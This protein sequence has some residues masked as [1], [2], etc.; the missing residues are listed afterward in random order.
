MA[1]KSDRIDDALRA[2]RSA[3][4]PPLSARVEGMLGSLLP[5]RTASPARGVAVVFAASLA[6]AALHVASNGPRPDAA[7]LPL[8]W[9]V[10]V[11]LAWAGGFLAVLAATMLPRRGS[12]LPDPARVVV[13]SLLGPVAM[14]ALG[15][16]AGGAESPAAATWGGEL[17]QSVICLFTALEI[18]A[19]PFV[20]AAFAMRRALPI[21]T[22]AVGAALGAAGGALG[23]LALHFR[24]VVGGA[25]HV[26]TAHG[27]AALAGALLGALVLPRA[28]G[29]RGE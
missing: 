8:A 25:L 12:V 21:E 23:A 6:I 4:P 26:G 19:V 20:G 15:A 2:L 17:R 1:A 5:A 22:R 10:L 16:T 13:A 3:R 11:A 28:L 27:G 7:R 14:I 9:V 18:G 29:S 24:C